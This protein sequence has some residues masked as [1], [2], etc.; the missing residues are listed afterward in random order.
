MIQYLPHRLAAIGGLGVQQAA[1][2]ADSTA[3]FA[4]QTAHSLA[5]A[6][7]QIDFL[8][9]IAQCSNRFPQI[10]GQAADSAAQPGRRAHLLRH[11]SDLRHHGRSH[12]IQRLADATQ[13]G[14]QAQ[15]H[16][17]IDGRTGVIQ[18]CRQN[19]LVT[20]RQIH[21]RGQSQLAADSLGLRCRHQQHGRQREAAADVAAEAHALGCQG[22]VLHVFLLIQVIKN[23]TCLALR[24]RSCFPMSPL[25]TGS[26]S[27]AGA[28]R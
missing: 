20:R 27:I 10:A 16:Q 8:H 24:Q 17:V 2:T 6:Q 13:R 26:G 18:R 21:L 23:F 9:A 1:C 5:Q 28:I 7:R 11:A 3:G 12:A 25:P 4:D 14:R 15:V 19:R 22:L